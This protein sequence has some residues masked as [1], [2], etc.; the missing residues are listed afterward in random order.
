MENTTTTIMGLFRQQ[1]KCRPDHS[2]IVCGE[3][4]LTYREADAFTDSIAMLIKA[5]GIGEDDV[6]GVLIHRNIFQ[7]LIPLAVA[8]AGC[9]YLALDNSYPEERI[10]WMME[11][12]SVKLLIADA[13]LLEIAGD[14]SVPVLTTES[15]K[16][17]MMSSGD[18]TVVADAGQDT[19][20]SL[21]YTSGSTGVP[22]GCMITRRNVVELAMS[23]IGAFNLNPQSRHANYASFSFIP[24]VLDTF[25]T[26]LAGATL[27]IVPEEIRYDFTALENYFN[28]N[29]I[30]STFMTTQVARQ[31]VLSCQCP[32]L[33]TIMGGGEKLSAIT[34]PEEL[35]F[36]NGYGSSECVGLI[37]CFEVKTAMENTPVGMPTGKFHA[38]VVDSQGQLVEDGEEGELWLSGPQLCKGYLNREEQTARDFTPN[39]FEQTEGYERVFHTGD[40][41][42]K[43]A[44]GNIVFACRKD[45]MVKIRGY[46]IELGEIE[47]VI[48]QYPE[49][50]S[51]VV[52]TF[53]DGNGGQA[54][55]A[56]IVADK[57]VDI[58]ALTRFIS[59]RKPPYM[60][61]AFITQLPQLPLNTN[62]KVDKAALPVP[63]V[64][65][66][67]L[68][69]DIEL[70]KSEKD[71]VE[72]VANVMS[73]D[74]L[75]P[76]S[77]LRYAGLTSIMAMRLASLLFKRYGVQ[78]DAKTILN[79]G[80]IRSISAMVEANKIIS[81]KQEKTEAADEL[82]LSAPLTYAQT[83]IYI[84]CA[85][86]PEAVTYNIPFMLRF[87]ESVKSEKLAETIKDVIKVHPLMKVHFEA[88]GDDII[89]VL[90][91]NQESNILQKQMTAEDLES[92]ISEFIRPFN[93]QTGPLYRFEIIECEQNAVLLFDVHHLIFD[94]SS[95]DLLI[96]QICNRLD[97]IM[98]E[99]ESLS[100]LQ[101]ALMQKNEKDESSKGFFKEVMHAYENATEIPVDRKNEQGK[102]GVLQRYVELVGWNIIQDFC[103]KHDITPAHLLLAAT[104]YTAS[105][106]TNS[107]DI[108][109]CSVSSG[110]GDLKV[111]DTT[112]MFVNTLPVYG[113]IGEGSVL[114]FLQQTRDRFELSLKHENY[115]FANIAAEYDFKPQLSFVYQAGLLSHYII[116]NETVQVKSLETRV[117]KFKL[118][119]QVF[120]GEI[121][122]L[123]DDA[124]YSH[125]TISGL[126]ESLHAVVNHFMENANQ[127]LRSVSIMSESQ[128]ALVEEI[129]YGGKGEPKFKLFYDSIRHWAK[130]KPNEPALVACD[131]SFSYAEMDAVTDNIANALA[132]MGVGLGDRVALLLPRTS[133]LILSMFG[134]QKAGAAYI[135]CDPEYPEDRVKLILED[136]EARFIITTSDRLGS[137]PEGKGIDVE[138]LLVPVEGNY[139]HAEPTPDDLAYL[140]YTSGSTGRPKGVMLRHEGVCNYSTADPANVEAY[141][142][143][144][145]A[146]TVLGVTTISF[147]AS[148][149][150]IGISI[151]NGL[152]L[153]LADEEQTKNP[154][155]MAEL[156]RKHHIGYVSATPSQW[157]TWIYSTEFVEA[158]K[159]VPIIRF[160][161]EKL[162]ESLLHQMQELT[163]S[164]IINTYGPT[165]TTVS[166][167]I[168]E[169]TKA[170]RVTVG[171]PQ[172]NV[173][174][175]IVDAD[176][177][178]L[179]VGVVG[180]LYIGGKGVGRGYNKLD[181][182]TNERFIDYHGT[183]IYKS[184]DYAKWLP[185]GDVVILGRTDH[186]IKL[187][188]LRI[189]LGEIET[190]ISN[191]PG[192]RQVV[193][194]IRKLG[195]VEHLCA[196]Y[197]ADMPIDPAD[198][199]AEIAKHLTD[200]MV[201]T[202]YLQLEKMP[203]TPNG[204][205]DIKSLPEP[206]LAG[207]TESASNAPRQLNRLE[208]EIVS[209]LSGILGTEDI[210]IEAPLNTL[211]ITSLTA[212]RLAVQVQQKFNVPLNAK[213][214]V[215]SGTVLSIEDSIISHLLTQPT[216]TKPLDTSA[217]KKN[218]APLSFA[219]TGVY[220][221]CMKAPTEIIYNIPFKMRMPEGVTPDKLKQAVMDV[222]KCHPQ[223]GIHFDISES[224][225]AQV[226][227]TAQPV[228][229]GMKKM[230]EEALPAYCRQFV[231][232]FNLKK[233]PLYRFE[234][235]E[236][237]E[238]VYLL[239][240][241]HHLI[242]DG[243]SHDLFNQQLCMR[244]EGKEIEKEKYT[245]IDFTLDEQKADQTDAKA[246]FD[247]QMKE[248]EGA[249]DIP[250]DLKSGAQHGRL[251]WTGAPFDLDG[252]TEF[253]KRENLT[254]ATVTLAAAMYT[255]ARYAN[256]HDVYISTISNGRSNLKISNTM[257]MFVNTLPLAA[258]IKEGSVMDFIRTTADK[259]EKTLS[260]EQYP[261]AQI[262]DS[263]GFRPNISFAYQLGVM[264]ETKVNGQQVI[265][266]PLDL[267]VPKFKI[268][269][270]ITMHEGAP[271][272]RI[273]YDDAFYSEELIRQLSENMATVISH[274]ITNQD[275]PVRK[276]SLLDE[277]QCRE[278]ITMSAG[279]PLDVDIN[280][281]FANLF[282]SQAKQSP[283]RLAVADDKCELTYGEMERRANILADKLIKAG[284]KP[285]SFVAVGLERTVLFPL[286]VLAIHKAGAAYLPLDLEYPNERL[287]YM[288]EDSQVP[289]LVTT[290]D[291]LTEKQEGGDFNVANIL[292]L[293]DMDWT[294]DVPEI[295]KSKPDGLAYIIYTSGSTG[296]PKG[297]MLH[298]AGLSNF[299][300]SVIDFASITADDRIAHHRSFSFDAH[301]EDLYPVLTLGGSLHIM[302]SDIRKDLQKMY[303]FILN[304]KITGGGYATP[305]AILM[306]NNF[307]LPVRYI[308]AG[309]DKLA[310]VKSDHIDIINVYGPTECTDDTNYY[311][312]QR[313]KDYDNIP[314]GTT[315]PNC[316]S[317]ITDPDGNLLPKGVAGELC[318][319]GIQVGCGYWNMPERTQKSF[320][321]CPFV[322]ID[323]FGRN[324]KMYHTGDLCKYNRDGLIDF[325]GR[326]DNQVKVNGF[327]I[328][329]GEIESIASQFSG[330]GEV[331]ATIK[332]IGVGKH[333]CLFY[334]ATE[335]DFSQDK[336]TEHIQNSSLAHY[337]QPDVYVRLDEMPHTLSGKINVKALPTPDLKALKKY[338]A[339]RNATEEKLCSIFADTLQLERVG[340]ND[341][342]FALGGTSLIAT[343]AVIDIVNAGYNITYGDLFKYKTPAA[344][345]AFLE[346]DSKEEDETDMLNRQLS[347]F[348]YRIID[349]LL[350][351]N[352]LEAFNSAELE[353]LGNVLLTGSTGFLGIHVLYEL[354]RRDDV[355]TITCLIRGDNTNAAENR[356]RTM[357]F[358][359]FGTAF[360]DEFGKRLFV[361]CGNVTDSFDEM[362][363]RKIDI[364]FNCAAN[365]KHFS[366]GTDIEDVN[367]GGA[368]RCI[369]FC[370]KRGAKLIHVST[371][372]TAGVLVD[373]DLSEPPMFNEQKLFIGQRLNTKYSWSKF[374]AERKILQA[375]ATQGLRAKIMR[376]GSL[377]ARSTD[378]EFQINFQ[379][380][381]SL[382]RLRIY[383]MLGA[384][385]YS[386][387]DMPIEFSP[388]NQTA[389]AIVLLA[390]TPDSCVVFHPFN[391]H[392]E[393]L[394][395]ILERMA[396]IG[397]DLSLVDEDD[398]QK[399]MDDAKNDPMKAEKMSGLIA[400]INAAHG[401]QTMVPRT[402]NQY[403]MQI[404]YRMNFKWDMTTWDYI[405][406]M[407]ATL[408]GFGYFDDPSADL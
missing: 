146:K 56:Y 228:N 99:S 325:I 68:S 70:S 270:F 288:M 311:I 220:F 51:A 57:T 319:A 218:S 38:Y 86:E 266:E 400:Y 323:R 365:V 334:T 61:P 224:M 353:S 404:L 230:S 307:D 54:L 200:Y 116:G 80:S 152:T 208:K 321:E 115:L 108:Y 226:I 379:T 211:G 405:D 366:K 1:V 134:V 302:P 66:C 26:L 378:G 317:F 159:Q 336:L 15:L 240:D 244:L 189:E 122:F 90:D 335:E 47:H 148:L 269:I 87:Q 89:Q 267:E 387:Y 197:T 377:S 392:R 172:F 199:R 162:P 296:K 156:I 123:Y 312:M 37:S 16:E 185:D 11:D 360:K 303:Q 362:V 364:V 74:A 88:K 164:R 373:S 111:A 388:I 359:Y 340:I 342:F 324:V 248:C 361:V 257:G 328:E 284:V 121:H 71:I 235:V 64:V 301:I 374:V 376:V 45:N 30:T 310:G 149:H 262:A 182:M 277:D 180:E 22:K 247:E 186:Q 351:K 370:I 217:D 381:S 181:E 167:N 352:S 318:F 42:K 81:T 171:H 118:Q 3:Q 144:N 160:G 18:D 150:E 241:I 326:I 173:V 380:N 265:I 231:Q 23:S 19:L 50:S 260:F 39:P 24:S 345:S 254:P 46:R 382:G 233:G 274:F 131:A 234:V 147:D 295:D 206:Q 32:A 176:G 75:G 110:R 84:E 94:G 275:A 375:V 285:D 397:F 315:I 69:G 243:G 140:I 195:G 124:Y 350:Q 178:E 255:I 65:A 72:I 408:H 348:D 259:F 276:I 268:D 183:R 279:K 31:F 177:N 385:P 104:I 263:Y 309:G 93:L 283:E 126:A 355:E 62:M 155:M 222:V 119:V 368:E 205:T 85:S 198:L 229:V 106:Y 341:D 287:Q 113:H 393:L 175:F 256:S 13:D 187:R 114:E 347:D 322:S 36:L 130:E 333:I 389:L 158:I 143:A 44:D 137:V 391:H 17:Q 327:R 29:A 225:V 281:T 191:Y 139:V 25:S 383:K 294:E 304:H 129:R 316:W 184:G 35:R 298:Q 371:M 201:P 168:Q 314:I 63:M 96:R 138:T 354:L 282:T 236:T 221:E 109:L 33:K 78:I 369:D 8:K 166:S 300:A 207:K 219:Q 289:V 161:G 67:T 251:E 59:E 83:G 403:T 14:L 4:Q 212:I 343:R 103:N 49:I 112:G 390:Q 133:R 128:K 271:A 117:P 372:S 82:P 41:V 9:A 120:E 145:A 40:I 349:D 252:L 306:L 196:Y 204:K 237:P 105:R 290:H 98:P 320:V 245:L 153:V 52:T 384:L 21:I 246:F 227:D 48:L 338:V 337:M 216:I 141:A 346:G 95:V 100:Y 292:L 215:K 7:A 258:H 91:L 273:G 53:D 249:T 291:V 28:N 154:M 190:A 367:I 238:A 356:L 151:F 135:P 55:A 396:N 107:R 407:F 272:I 293:D 223:F 363:K 77:L 398:F 214:L 5:C 193:V 253:C 127:R 170:E 188:G 165:E 6:V 213:Q 12:A 332:T 20:L 102:P 331:A 386:Q 297:A 169:L 125:Q 76:D 142:V 194:M 174:E 132:K 308:T 280:L 399:R 157:Q 261:F 60:V 34:P 210:D 92:Y 395:D 313:G 43:D 73:I 239:G 27:Y 330:I 329:L 344:L 264:N 209:I 286:T 394:G 401:K 299:I 232:P 163:P 2:A 278:I 358:Y 10:R 101:F 202:A 357:L 402:V 58:D 192:V 79:E 339:P 305:M 406:R 136:S 242:F 250:A 97:G 179:P 203:M